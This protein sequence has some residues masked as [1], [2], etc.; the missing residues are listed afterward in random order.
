[1]AQHDTQSKRPKYEV[2]SAAEKKKGCFNVRECG[3][4]AQRALHGKLVCAKQG[5]TDKQL[6]IEQKDDRRADRKRQ[7]QRSAGPGMGMQQS[8]LL[9]Q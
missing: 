3:R 6:E 1:M 4:K 8:M 5:C 7:K 2:I 9:S